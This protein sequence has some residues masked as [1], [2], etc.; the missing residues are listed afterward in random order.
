MRLARLHIFTLVLWVLWACTPEVPVVDGDQ[1]PAMGPITVRGLVCDNGGLPLKGVVV[2]DCNRCVKTDDAGV[3][4]LD[5]DIENSKFVFV[6]IPSGYTV[7]TENG[8]PIFYKRLSEAEMIDGCYRV[9]F[10]LDKMQHDP[11][12][13]SILMVADPQPRQRDRAFDK[14]AYH[15]LDCC[16]DLYRD[17]R[18]TGSAILADRPCYAIVLGDIVHEDMSLFDEYI[19]EGT[20][21]MGFPTFN[22]IGNHDHD[23]ESKTDIEGA[24]AFEE[25]FGPTNYSFNLGKVHYIVVDDMIQLYRNGSLSKSDLGLRDEIVRWVKSDLSFVDKSSTI[26]ICMHAPI[27]LKSKT[28]KNREK[29]AEALSRF[30]KVHEWSGHAHNMTNNCETDLANLEAHGIVRA[31][32][33][34]W[35][36]EY[37][38]VGV[39]RGYVVVNVDGEDISWKFKPTIYQSGQAYSTTPDYTYRSWNYR[40]GVARMKS[41]GK[42]LDDTYQMNVYPRG[43]YEDSYVY[44]NVFMWDQK[45]KK[46]VYVTVGGNEYPMNHVTD[47]SLM[48]D[49]GSLEIFDFYDTNSSTFQKYDS[50]SWNTNYGNTI[51]SAFLREPS[52]QGDYVKVTDR[53]GNEYRQEV[54]I[55]N[56]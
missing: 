30:S 49:V 53:F 47:S 22:V 10:I 28:A 1:E 6:S 52:K 4:E 3:F 2:S 32:G 13:Y 31:T 33:E 16:K 19:S 43:S 56:P 23:T 26:M 42:Q 37:L 41:D 17:M 21:K 50:Y 5:T 35:T 24:W 9:E 27:F 34:L 20:S 14:V 29:L 48:Y 39:P 25:K 40:G 54:I 38:S 55:I 45:W 12:R 8:L 7:P 15:S 11:D 46:P 36:N 44:A 51:F 18:E